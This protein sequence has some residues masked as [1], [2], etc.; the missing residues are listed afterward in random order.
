MDP[1]YFPLVTIFGPIIGA[2]IGALVTYF[3]VV[4]RKTVTFWISKS[5]DL[6]LPLRQEHDLIVFKIGERAMPNLN[7]ARIHVKNTGNTPIKDF[8]FDIEIP[9]SHPHYLAKTIVDDRKIKESISIDWDDPAKPTGPQFHVKM[10]F[11]NYRN[12]FKVAVYFDGT[13]SECNVHCWLEDVR[14][15]VKRGEYVSFRAAILSLEPASVVGAV[16]AAAGAV[17]G[18]V[19]VGKF[20]K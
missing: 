16:V 14:T 12:D 15:R 6:T 11:L 13:T 9:G 1:K 5:D 20:F 17:L 19:L 10:P 2:I 4:K 3:V 8:G 18:A 7:M